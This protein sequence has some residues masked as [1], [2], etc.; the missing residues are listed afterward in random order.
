MIGIS[1]ALRTEILYLDGNPDWDVPDSTF[2][3]M[4]DAANEIDRLTEMLKWIVPRFINRM[5]NDESQEVKDVVLAAMEM[6]R[7]S[8]LEDE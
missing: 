2:G 7:D 4:D 5:G 6:I 8:G 1:D 3:F